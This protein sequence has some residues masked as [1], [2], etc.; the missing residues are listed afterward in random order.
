MTICPSL[1]I[2]EA[3]WASRGIRRPGCTSLAVPFAANIVLSPCP[4]CEDSEVRSESVSSN[5]GFTLRR[6]I[7]PTV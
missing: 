4:T 6:G 7:L 2:R 3:Q 5:T 1:T